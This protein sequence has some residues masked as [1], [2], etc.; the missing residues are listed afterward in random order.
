MLF[1]AR[2]ALAGL[3][4][5]IYLGNMNFEYRLTLP[6]AT[7]I[8]QATSIPSVARTLRAHAAKYGHRDALLDAYGVL[9]SHLLG[10]VQLRASRMSPSLASVGILSPM[11]LPFNDTFFGDAVFGNGGRPEGFR[12]LM[13]ECNRFYRTC[14]V[15]PRKKH[16]GIEFVL[17]L[18]EAELEFLRDDDEFNR[19]AFHIPPFNC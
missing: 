11:V 6:L 15:V 14:F 3:L 2:P 5:P 17:T 7:L 10:D 13:G 18:P 8:D 16:G 12:P 19:Y 1:D 9:R 4:P